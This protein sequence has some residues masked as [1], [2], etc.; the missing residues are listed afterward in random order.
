VKQQ[1]DE[2]ISQPVNEINTLLQDYKSHIQNIDGLF[3]HS[4]EA[5]LVFAYLFQGIN[6]LYKN[7]FID[8]EKQEVSFRKMSF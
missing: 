8:G 1:W 4:D 6:F 7:S 3:D 2:L 5:N